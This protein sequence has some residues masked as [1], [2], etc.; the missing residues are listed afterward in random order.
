M[1]VQVKIYFAHRSN[2]LDT[3]ILNTT[4]DAMNSEWNHAIST[5]KDIFN[6]TDKNGSRLAINVKNV[7]LFVCVPWNGV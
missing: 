7:E 1:G 3:Y 2:S 5:G 4:P 6:L